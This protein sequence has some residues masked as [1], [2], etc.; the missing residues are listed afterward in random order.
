MSHTVAQPLRPLTEF[1]R[2]ELERVSRAPSERVNRHQR[3]VAL[4]A[5][6]AGKTLTDAAK[7]AG[8]KVHDTVTRLIRRFN[9]C[10]LAALDDLPRS[11]H[12]RSYGPTERVRIE[13]ELRRSPQLREDGTAT[14]SLT[15]L[16]RALRDAPDG[17]PR[18]STFTL[19]H[20]LHEMGYTWQKDR[21]WCKTGTR[22]HKGKKGVEE[23]HDPY[24]QEKQTVIE[25]AYLI[26]ERLGLELWCEDEGG[27][28]QSIPQPGSSWQLEGQPARRPHEYLR[29][30]V[31]KLLTLFRPATGEVRAEAVEH[32]TNAVLHPWLKRELEA[33]LK[34]CPPAPESVPEGRRW[35]DWDIYPAAEQ[36]DRFFPPVRVLLILDNLAGHK[37][38][39][40]VQWCAEHGILLLWTPTSGS[41]LNMAESVQRIIKGRALNGQHPANVQMLKQW[42]TDAVEGWNRHPT[43]FIWGGKRHARRDRAYARR[44]RLGGSGATTV[45]AVPRRIRSVRYYK[46]AA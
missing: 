27:P 1:E 21:T 45:Y 34:Q 38:Y 18:V 41:W 6:D 17:L 24:T 13:R 7:E 42:L 14:W 37:S 39:R 20:A 15:T 12:P 26:A 3:A 31:A 28:Y 10:G 22:L 46:R 30:E 33:I 35:Q 5:V 2:G 8:W 40:L 32:S 23:R 11:G 19:L 25:H 29:G 44:H 9:E 4:L 43:P 16:Q 36:L